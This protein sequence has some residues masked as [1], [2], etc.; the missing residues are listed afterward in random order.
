[1]RDHRAIAPCVEYVA[2]PPDR[3]E[4]EAVGM[5]PNDRPLEP[6]PEELP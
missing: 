6:A 3:R 4:D 2:R 5:A 1:M